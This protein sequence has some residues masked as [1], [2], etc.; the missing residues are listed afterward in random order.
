MPRVEKYKKLYHCFLDPC[1]HAGPCVSRYALGW[2]ENR[3]YH[4]F[5]GW[6]LHVVPCIGKKIGF[7]IVFFISLCMQDLWSLGV[8][9]IGKKIGFIIVFLI[10]YAWRTFCAWVCPVLERKEAASVFSLSIWH[11]GPFVFGYAHG[12]RIEGCIIV[13][14]ISLS[15]QDL[16]CLGKPM[17]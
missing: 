12:E 16:L 7:I 17:V 3:L 2:K 4:C 10:V 11:A 5:F 9:H 6:C 14:L 15:M 13:F 1:V 8:P